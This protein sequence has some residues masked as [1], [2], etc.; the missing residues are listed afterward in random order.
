MK[1]NRR[2]TVIVKTTRR[3]VMKVA[4]SVEAGPDCVE[5]GVVMKTTRD[6]ALTLGIGT[7]E[8]FQLVESNRITFV[9][10]AERE[11]FVCP[12]CATPPEP[13]VPTRECIETRPSRENEPRTTGM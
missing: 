2:A 6:A 13:D 12:A 7:R 3:T 10:T 8:V 1:I 5:C 4:N 11:T 9:E